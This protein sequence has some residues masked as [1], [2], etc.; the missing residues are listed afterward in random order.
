MH[1]LRQTIW[2]HIWKH[3]V[4]KGQTNATSAAIWGHIWKHTV[5]KNQ[6]MLL[7]QTKRAGVR[8]QVRHHQIACG[9]PLLLSD[10]CTKV[11]GLQNARFGQQENGWGFAPEHQSS[12]EGSTSR[13][14]PPPTTTEGTRAVG[15]LMAHWGRVSQHSWVATGLLSHWCTSLVNCFGGISYNSL[16]DL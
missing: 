16:P 2:G 1:P 9:P 13:S 14:G 10:T 6:K 11:V 5:V 8:R 12:P 3:T 15:Q 4:E 7:A